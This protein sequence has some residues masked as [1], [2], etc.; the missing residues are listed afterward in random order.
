M[1]GHGLMQWSDGNMY[2]GQWQDNKMH[3]YGL[4]KQFNGY[5]YEG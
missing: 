3:G 5:S 4:E 2:E 1:H